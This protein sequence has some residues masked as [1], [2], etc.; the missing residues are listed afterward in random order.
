[1]CSNGHNNI[2]CRGNTRKMPAGSNHMKKGDLKYYPR[3]P[4]RERERERE[5]DMYRIKGI[6]KDII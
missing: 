3:E 5:I 1:M 4:Q 6:S 2:N